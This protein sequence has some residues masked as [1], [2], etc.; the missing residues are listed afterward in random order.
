MALTGEK[1]VAANF[2]RFLTGSIGTTCPEWLKR[3]PG[4]IGESDPD[5]SRD[6]NYQYYP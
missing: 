6:G 1:R 2:Y 4:L 3:M 5:Y